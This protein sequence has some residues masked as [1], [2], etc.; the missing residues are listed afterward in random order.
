MNDLAGAI[1][2]L[3]RMLCDLG[4]TAQAQ[5]MLA[6]HAALDSGGAER[7]NRLS[8]AGMGSLSDLV[9]FPGDQVTATRFR[10][11]LS[12]C[13]PTPRRCCRE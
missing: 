11:L 9:L 7:L 3:H 12:T 5:E 10:G 4:R 8:S 13:T 1:A 6:A 2:E